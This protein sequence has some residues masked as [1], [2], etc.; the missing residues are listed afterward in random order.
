MPSRCLAGE[1]FVVGRRP[2]HDTHA[3][4]NYKGV[5]WCELCGAYAALAPR[6]LALA[7]VPGIAPNAAR[8]LARL[9]RGELPTRVREWPSERTELGFEL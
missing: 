6:A 7:C 1:V 3:L 9:N 4:W 8:D 5:Y 2:L